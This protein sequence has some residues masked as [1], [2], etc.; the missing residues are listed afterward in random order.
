MSITRTAAALL[1]AIVAALALASCGGDDAKTATATAPPT[2][3]ATSGASATATGTRQPDTT[4]T[5]AGESA[6]VTIENF[7]FNPAALTVAVGTTV[8]WVNQDTAAHR[9]VATTAGGFNAGTAKQGESVSA[10]FDAA[11]VFPYICEF[12]PQMAGTI[13]VE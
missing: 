4:A 8:S 1:T 11:G 10:T 2:I 13:T 5:P 12:H 7:A 9:M 3:T 6:E